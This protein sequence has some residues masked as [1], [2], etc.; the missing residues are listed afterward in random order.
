MDTV[1]RKDALGRAG[2]TLVELL[3]VIAIIGIL[4][5]LLLP[6][7]QAAREAARR[8][9][10]TNNLKQLGLAHLNFESAKGHFP[11]GASY[12]FSQPC[13]GSGGC[14]AWTHIHL[15]LPYFEEGVIN[16]QIE[17][18]TDGGWLNFFRGLTEAE[19]DLFD[20]ARIGALMCPSIS[21][22]DEHY[23]GGYRRDYFGNLGGRGH[24]SNATV[25]RA[26]PD[27]EE[28]PLNHGHGGMVDDGMLFINSG[29]RFA[30]ITDGSSHTMLMGECVQ[31][32][33]ANLPNT[34][35]QT[36]S[37]DTGYTGGPPEWF[38]GASG[39]S[40]TN[41]AYDRTL[42]SAIRPLNTVIECMEQLDQN[43]LPFGSE[44]PGGST[45]VFADG[46]VEFKIDGID[47]DVYQG[48]STRGK[49]E[50]IGGE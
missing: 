29:V 21:K 25:S 43:E 14:R 11:D 16:D 39:G 9:Q 22:W 47:F 41:M 20:N 35:C 18:D 50:D 37:G 3:V 2:F 1:K 45:F 36:A 28:Q 7:V 15:V 8:M 26:N 32:G 17:F 42:R 12:D 19:K 13:P 33:W 31:G 46:H 40:E 48:L 10:C 38:R 6:A 24:S 5:A 27:G 23:G 44:H 4:V 30:E 34:T 49:G